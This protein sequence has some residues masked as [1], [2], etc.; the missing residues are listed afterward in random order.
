MSGMMNDRIP[1]TDL[2]AHLGNHQWRGRFCMAAGNLLEFTTRWIPWLWITGMDHVPSRG[3]DHRRGLWGMWRGAWSIAVILSREYS[4]LDLSDI[5]GYLSLP[6]LCVLVHATLSLDQSA[7]PKVL[8]NG[9]TSWLKKLYGR[10]PKQQYAN[11]HF[12]QVAGRCSTSKRTRP[13][14]EF[15]RRHHRSEFPHHES[16]KIVPW[17]PRC[18]K[19]PQQR[20]W[21]VTPFARSV[22]RGGSWLLQRQRLT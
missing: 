15:N 6:C 21:H 4:I 17:M 5:G 14:Q 7:R 22:F 20:T 12:S 9:C 13:C 2:N 1:S 8:A 10:L 11:S 16:G 19:Q 18:N 3:L